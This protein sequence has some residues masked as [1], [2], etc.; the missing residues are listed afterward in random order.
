MTRKANP[1]A[2]GIFVII[3]LTILTITFITLF[4]GNIF[5]HTT[6]FVFYFK[7]SVNGL[8]VGSAVKFKGVR[9]GSVE[10]IDVLYDPETGEVS[11]PVIAEINTVVFSPSAQLL[12][13][14]ERNDFYRRQIMSG[15]TAKLGMESLVTGKL[16]IEL[17]YLPGNSMRF[18]GKNGTHFPQIPTLTSGIE[19]FI[20]GADNII[21][22]FNDIDFQ[23]ISDRLV[24]I[25]S[26]FDRQLQSVSLDELV[27]NL[28]NAAAGV[29]S[30]FHSDS[31][32]SLVDHL[33]AVVVDLQQ[34]LAQL[35]G[36]ICRVESDIS[37]T[38]HGIRGA[39]NQFTETCKDVSDLLDSQSDVRSSF[40][41]FL[42]TGAR[43]LQSLHHLLDLL[44][45]TPNAIFA[46]VDYE[47]KN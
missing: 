42:L 8:D 31:A 1:L 38:T 4:P 6:S 46:G 44:N 23:N 11:T 24:S 13:K 37:T 36:V 12:P 15:L 26:N 47:N 14:S 7:G 35:S 16:F 10:S 29:G 34:F 9:I 2:V 19:K 40:K 30:F 27:A 18:Y 20:S 45:K 41:A 21:K 22:K 25:L 17:D 39:A 43:A 5:Q 32:G 33:R 3:A 28:S